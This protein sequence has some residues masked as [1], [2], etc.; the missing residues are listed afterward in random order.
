MKRLIL[1]AMVAAAMAFAPK[2]EAGVIIDFATGG[3]GATGTIST[4]GG[5]ITSGSNISMGNMTIS[6]LLSLLNGV[7]D[8]SGTGANSTTDAIRALFGVPL[9]GSAVLS[10]N[11]AAGTFQIDGGIGG[12][13]ASLAGG[14]TVANTTPL[15]TGTLISFTSNGTNAVTF[16]GGNV[17]L[18]ASFAS[19][20]GITTVPW[21]V[22]F[23]SVIN[24]LGQT[25]SA[26]LNITAVP[27]PG[28]M[29]LLG[30]GLLGV[31]AIARRRLRK[32]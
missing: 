27:E 4:S 6:G 3:T 9:N 2:A 19:A 31:A 23:A 26:D 8:T 12:L 14:S 32:Q 28:S 15:V 10:F 13:D 22:N 7:Y 20:F 16:I 21:T 18:A 29:I 30:T 25:T 17:V 24:N 11:V 5:L 1:V